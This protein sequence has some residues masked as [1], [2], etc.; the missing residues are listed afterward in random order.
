MDSELSD[1]PRSPSPLAAKG[2]RT[3]KRVSA[4]AGS[5]TDY[6]A[7]SSRAE[8]ESEDI[9]SLTETGDE[10]YHNSHG[11]SEIEDW[12]A[13]ESRKPE[14]VK[15]TALPPTKPKAKPPKTSRPGRS[16]DKVAQLVEQTEGLSIEDIDPDDSVVVLPNRKT[17]SSN[18]SSVI[19]ASSQSSA[20]AKKKKR[21][22]FGLHANRTRSLIANL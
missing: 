22:E 18:A 14:Q 16:K 4:Q 15:K 11:H 20:D 10:D 8:E 7:S 12:S 21:Y 17:R 6:Y 5:G 13:E 1:L 3:Q 9:S 19:S 2:L